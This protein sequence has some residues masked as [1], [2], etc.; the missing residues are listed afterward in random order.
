MVLARV[1]ATNGLNVRENPT[2][3]SK[4]VGILPFGTSITIVDESIVIADGYE[5]N[6]IQSPLS[7]WVVAKYIER[8][9]IETEFKFLA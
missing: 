2:V 8:I 9:V 1:I 7:G 6:N 4:K 5:W 3:S